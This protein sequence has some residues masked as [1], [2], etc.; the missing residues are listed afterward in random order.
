VDLCHRVADEGGGLKI[1][2]I[3]ANVL[4]KQSRTAAKGCP[5]AWG[6]ADGLTTPHLKKTVSYEMLHRASEL[7]GLL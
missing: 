3:A 6:L 1:W 7:S 5:V 4:N 2:W